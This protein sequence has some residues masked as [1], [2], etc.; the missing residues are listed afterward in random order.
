[1][2]SVK[3]EKCFKEHDEHQKSNGQK[4]TRRSWLSVNASQ[5]CVIWDILRSFFIAVNFRR[6]IAI[7]SSYCKVSDPKSKNVWNGFCRWLQLPR[8]VGFAP[9]SPATRNRC[10]SCCTTTCCRSIG[11]ASNLQKFERFSRSD[12]IKETPKIS[13]VCYTLF[14][15]NSKDIKVKRKEWSLISKIF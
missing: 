3:V 15:M 2:I 7:L 8:L 4:M 9:T 13:S 11:A 10:T 6:Y 1:M 12:D 5:R 14:W